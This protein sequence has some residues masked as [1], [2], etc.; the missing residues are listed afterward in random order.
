MTE[1]PRR[2][3]SARALG[4]GLGLGLSVLAAVGLAV[5]VRLPPAVMWKALI[6]S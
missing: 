6:T 5:G 2:F 3:P 1:P 4:L